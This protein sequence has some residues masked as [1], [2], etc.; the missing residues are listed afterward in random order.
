VNSD[1]QTTRSE[2][3]A[4]TRDGI[5]IAYRLHQRGDA[6]PRAVLIHSLAMD[7]EF[8]EAVVPLLDASVL[9]FDCRGHGDSD[10]PAGPYTAEQ[11]ADDLADLM[12]HVG[13][14]SA[15][16]GGASM[17]GCVS[18]AFAAAYPQR[19]LALGLFDTTAWYGADAPKLWEERATKGAE[20]GLASLVGF[21]MT[22]W[23]ADDFR[24]AHPD[25]VQ[26][27]VE[28]FVRNDVKA[29]GETCRMLGAADLRNT[30]SRIKVPTAIVVGDEDYATPVP[31]AEALHAAIA[32][33]SYKLLHK[34]R[35][36]TPI[37]QP[38]AIA[39]ELNRLL[40]AQT[41]R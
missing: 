34:A 41:A 20:E 32:G 10:K 22:R 38:Q 37:E 6:K 33:S 17:G 35:H 15:L 18:L 36:L 40:A 25:V 9:L 26:Q 27:C 3:K 24:A 12:D 16:I 13:W 5:K 28:I 1:Q 2:G 31:M 39:A 8:W 30:L 29:Y 19:T 11:F 23:F 4:T 21:Q 7:R 14:K